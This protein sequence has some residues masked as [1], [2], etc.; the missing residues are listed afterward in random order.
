MPYNNWLNIRN[1]HKLLNVL[2]LL[3]EVMFGSHLHQLCVCGSMKHARQCVN[4][5]LPYMGEAM[6]VLLPSDNVQR[7]SRSRPGLILSKWSVHNCESLKVASF[8]I[9][10]PWSP[11]PKNRFT[12]GHWWMTNQIQENIL[13]FTIFTST[14]LYPIGWVPAMHTRQRNWNQRR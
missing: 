5:F 7:Y 3:L 12:N 10:F 6:R 2:L 11:E 1:E 13:A 4:L 14:S 8:G 9:I